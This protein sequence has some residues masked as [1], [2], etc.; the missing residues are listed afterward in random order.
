MVKVHTL[1]QVHG[2]DHSDFKVSKMSIMNDCSLPSLLKIQS[3]Q[4]WLSKAVTHLVVE[5]SG[6]QG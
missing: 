4:L 1:A 5:N 3:S 6:G 2:M